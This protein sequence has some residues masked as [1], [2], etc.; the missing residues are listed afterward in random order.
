MPELPEVETIRLQ[1]TDLIVGLKIADIQTLHP[2]SFIGDYKLAL[3]SKITSVK[4]FGKMLVID[5]TNG[6][7]LAIH[8]K[9]T[10]QLILRG[11]RQLKYISRHTGVVINLPNKHTRVAITFTN[12]EKLFFNDQRIFGWIRVVRNNLITKPALSVPV[13]YDRP[14]EDTPI[15]KV[16]DLSNLIKHLG[17]EP[18]RDLSLG[19]FREILKSSKKPVKLILMDQEKIAGV[20]NIYANE[21]LFLA[22]IRPTKPANALSNGSIVS[23]FHCLERVLKNGI[24]WRGASKTNFVDAFGRKGSKQEHFY[25]YDRE[26][27]MCANQCGGKIIRIKVGGR[28]TFYCPVC[29]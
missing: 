11:N 3:Q 7:S 16:N 27:E 20:G 10:G 18:L 28:G 4:R 2:K 5:L 23:L 1:L 26:G 12:G 19:K 21:S 29:Q 14:T 24:K 25:V 9:M 6:L 13:C 22:G 8:L 15:D 17:P